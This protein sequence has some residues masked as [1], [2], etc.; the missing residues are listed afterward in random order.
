MSVSEVHQRLEGP[1][2]RALASRSLLRSFALCVFLFVS[3]NQRA[4]IESFKPPSR[5]FFPHAAESRAA[6]NPLAHARP[7]DRRPWA[8]HGQRAG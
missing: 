7:A 5:C 4:I 1:L 8:G 6:G 3:L 2:N